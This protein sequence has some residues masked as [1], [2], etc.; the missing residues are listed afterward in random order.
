MELQVCIGSACH[1]KGSY[2]VIESLKRLIAENKLEDKL[3][4]KASF[5][6][7]KCGNGV[8]VMAG[9]QFL[10]NVTPLTIDDIFYNTLVPMVQK[11]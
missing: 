11:C 2:E 5:C 6:L 7:G 9:E 3:I 4:L 8:T 10:D 1:L